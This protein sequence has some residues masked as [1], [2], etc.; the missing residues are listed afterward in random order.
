[1]LRHTRLRPRSGCD[2]RHGLYHVA[3]YVMMD[4]IEVRATT[5]TRTTA[6]ATLSRIMLGRLNSA[7]RAEIVADWWSMD[8]SD[9]RYAALPDDLR[10]KLETMGPP[11][12]GTYPCYDPLIAVGLA[13]SL[14]GVRN[15]WLEAQLASNNLGC[16]AVHGAV[17]ALVACPCCH[18][19]TLPKRG[20]YDICVVC[21]WEDDGSDEPLRHSGPNHATLAVARANFARFGAATEADR[22]H[23]LSD[24]PERYDRDVHGT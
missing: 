18:Y 9:P 13:A 23:V 1:M 19:R 21:F 11:A 5:M 4:A 2:L 10:A 3:T 8:A 17:E 15:A 14:A 6:V 20:E 12:D 22:L 24:G 16:V 7:Q